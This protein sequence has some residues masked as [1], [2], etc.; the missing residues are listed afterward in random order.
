MTDRVACIPHQI[1]RRCSCM[2]RNTVTIMP[3][4]SGD[5]THDEFTCVCG[6]RFN[7]TAIWVSSAQPVTHMETTNPAG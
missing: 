5:L 1:H 3:P 6:A 4:F 7:V 2:R